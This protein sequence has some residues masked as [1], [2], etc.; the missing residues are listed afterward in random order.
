M[1]RASGQCALSLVC[2]GLVSGSVDLFG[3][4]SVVLCEDLGTR[5]WGLLRGW[6]HG[7]RKTATAHVGARP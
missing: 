2:A 7:P 6:A 5:L 1:V 4:L 3:W